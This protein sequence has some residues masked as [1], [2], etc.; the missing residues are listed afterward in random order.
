MF[1]VFKPSLLIVLSVG[2]IHTSGGLKQ[3]IAIPL[4]PT[5]SWAIKDSS[6]FRF[7]RN[8]YREIHNW[9]SLWLFPDTLGFTPTILSHCFIMTMKAVRLDTKLRSDGGSHIFNMSFTR[10]FSTTETDWFLKP[11]ILSNQTYILV[12]L[13]IAVFTIPVECY[14]LTVNWRLW[15]SNCPLHSGALG[16]CGIDGE[17][18]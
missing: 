11:D 3:L 8:C 2:I 18:R 14:K 10:K 17:P 6:V 12:L 9:P 15:T 4:F 1:H 7:R 5:T 13:G 16:R